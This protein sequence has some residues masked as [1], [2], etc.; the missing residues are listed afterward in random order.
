MHMKFNKNLLFFDKL[1]KAQE[2][3]RKNVRK[4]S[5]IRPCVSRKVYSIM[6]QKKTG[7]IDHESKIME[8]PEG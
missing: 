6:T 5:G 4:N 7:E 8:K 2:K 1:R 3:Q